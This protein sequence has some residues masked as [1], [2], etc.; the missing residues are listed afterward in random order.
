MGQYSRGPSLMTDGVTLRPP[1]NNN[2]WK[3]VAFTDRLK[4][5]ELDLGEI[6]TVCGARLVQTDEY[7]ATRWCVHRASSLLPPSAQGRPIGRIGS[8]A[9]V[10]TCDR[11]LIVLT[12]ISPGAYSVQ[13]RSMAL[14]ARSYKQSRLMN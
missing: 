9:S 1:L 2:H 10:F 8:P 5:L 13:Q 11:T 12:C 6:Q 4:Q 14:G 3:V 7:Y